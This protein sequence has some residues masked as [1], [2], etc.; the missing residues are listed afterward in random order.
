MTIRD[1]Y[2]YGDMLADGDAG[3]IVGRVSSG[4]ISIINCFVKADIETSATAFG[5]GAAGGIVA[6]T[7]NGVYC[8][9]SGCYFNGTLKGVS[10]IGGI[11]G[12]LGGIGIIE[13]CVSTGEIMGVGLA[14][15]GIA[16]ATM[17]AAIK[18]CY[19]RSKKGHRG[20]R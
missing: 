6:Q 5:A 10:G 17:A 19:T 15:G 20:Q 3:G 2:V 1:C 7:D 14:R 13:N 16:G 8:F 11:A 12:N 4:N 18:N 9:I